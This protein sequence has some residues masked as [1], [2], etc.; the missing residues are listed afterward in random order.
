MLKR[1]DSMHR[2]QSNLTL[3]GCPYLNMCIIPQ[4]MTQVI[5]TLHR[6]PHSLLHLLLFLK[7][8]GLTSFSKFKGVIPPHTNHYST[9]GSDHYVFS[10]K[11]NHVYIL[12][13]LLAT[14]YKYCRTSSPFFSTHQCLKDSDTSY[15]FFIPKII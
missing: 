12:Q 4:Q 14:N 7:F 9:Y 8:Q 2:I 13:N 6:R 11:A 10:L 15:Y 1:D 3:V 5:L